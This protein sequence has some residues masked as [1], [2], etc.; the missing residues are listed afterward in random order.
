MRTVTYAERVALR[1]RPLRSGASTTAGA[2]HA[3]SCADFFDRVL[4]LRFHLSSSPLLFDLT[5]HDLWRR[6]SSF[7]APPPALRQ[8]S[9]RPPAALSLLLACTAALVHAPMVPFRSPLSLSRF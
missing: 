9:P 3:R 5:G 7:L 6:T 8:R 2:A 4:T 1:G